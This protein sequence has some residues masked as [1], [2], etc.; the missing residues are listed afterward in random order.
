MSKDDLISALN[1]QYYKHLIIND[2]TGTPAQVAAEILRCRQ[3]SKQ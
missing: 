2:V 3:N 1:D